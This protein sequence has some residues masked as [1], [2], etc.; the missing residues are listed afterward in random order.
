MYK[1]TI[2]YVDFG[3]IERT[4]DFYFNL[5]EAECMKM[6]FREEGGMTV[7]LN[8]IIAAKNGRKIMDVFENFIKQAYG[9]KSPNGREFNKSEEEYQ[10]FASTN[11]YSQLYMRLCTDAEYAAKFVE[12]VLPPKKAEAAGLPAAQ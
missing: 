11:A 8:Q 10:K 3:N 7:M 2:T 12:A 1:E 9:V 5:S 4:E 6:Q